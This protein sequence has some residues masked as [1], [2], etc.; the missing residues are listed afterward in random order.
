MNVVSLYSGILGLDAAA[1]AAGFTT[2]AACDSE[3]FCRDVIEH[4]LPS[5]PVYAS[6]EEITS[7]RLRADGVNGDITAVIGGPPCQPV[8]T[9]GQRL[10]PTDIRWRW[11]QFIRVVGEIRPRWF[12]AENPQGILSIQHG[13]AFS[14]LLSEM[15]HLGYALAWATYGASAVGAPHVRRRVFILGKR[16]DVAHTE[17]PGCQ[18]RR[19]PIGVETPFTGFTDS[20]K[21]VQPDKNTTHITGIRRMDKS[22]LGELFNGFPAELVTHPR[23]PSRPNGKQQA[24]EPARLTTK[25]PTTVQRLQALGNAVVPAQAYPVFKAI[26]DVELGRV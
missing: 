15:D 13:G 9:A 21:N 8:S 19:L 3:P 1:H 10:G 4:Y 25:E 18:K 23:W 5:I 7:A 17:K 22:R 26:A 2:V 24:W 16:Y 14:W 11:P 12:V 6:D 20:R